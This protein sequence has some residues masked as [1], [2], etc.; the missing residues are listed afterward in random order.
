MN[1]TELR[2]STPL[3]NALE[4][5]EI[6]YPTPI[7]EQTYRKATAGNDIVGI[8]RTGTG[9][10]F[11]YLLP[12]LN[13]LEFSKQQHPR[14]LII[15][16]TRELVMQVK[17]EAEKLSKYKN[18]RI[19]EIFGGANINTQKEYIY[20]G[21]ADIIIGTPGRLYDIA[22]TGILK[23]SKI[24]KVII[25]EVDE[26]L[27][28]GFR[29]QIEQI[30]EMMPQKKQNLMFSATLS[31]EVDGFIK[32]Y[33]CEPV[34]IEIEDN[35]TPIEKIEQR[36]FAVPN[37]NTKIEFL[38]DLLKNKE[39]IKNLIFVANKKQADYVFEKLYVEFGEAIG[40]IH[41]NKSQN[42]RF[43]TIKKFQKAEIK[44]LIATDVVAKGLDF[45][46]ISHVINL[47]VPENFLTYIHRIGRTGRADKNGES[48]LMLSPYEEVFYEEIE[49]NINTNLLIETIPDNIPISKNLLEEEKPSIAQKNYL[50][51]PN[52]KNSGGAFHPK[53]EKKQ[54]INSAELKKKVR[55]DKK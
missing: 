47:T 7:Q 6:V 29:P 32:K 20:D 11:A 28:L 5:L 22:V 24:K 12:T 41:S 15:V 30:L 10:T 50:K 44:T 18:V 49:K 16:P 38:K 14:V 23:L 4:D 54:K 3:L 8:S 34:K 1:F 40:V 48:I 52:I 42:F 9:K 53:G 31:S 35:T 46:N 37:F 45:S 33:F 25:D 39:L 21:G 13:Q 36:V 55:K 51:T 43:N 19:K 26:L 27:S 17:E 2:V